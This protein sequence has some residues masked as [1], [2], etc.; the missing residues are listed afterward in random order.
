MIAIFFF[1]VFLLTGI[2]HLD[3]I[4]NELI[5]AILAVAEA[6]FWYLILSREEREKSAKVVQLQE[7]IKKM[8][9]DKQCPTV[10]S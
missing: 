3:P 7:Q 6:P 9:E 4:I 5:L 1:L 10:D 8:E 2:V